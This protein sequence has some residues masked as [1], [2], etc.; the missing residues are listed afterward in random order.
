MAKTKQQ[1]QDMLASYKDRLGQATGVIV[2]SQTG[3]TPGDVSEFKKKLSAVDGSYSVVK[4]TIFK[5]A[6]AE[7]DLPSLDTFEAGPN[8]VIFTSED[9]A[10]TAKIVAEF[11]KQFKNNVEVRG[12][13]L[14]GQ[15]LTMAQVQ[16]LSELP[17][18]EQSIAMIAGLLEQ[19]I[20]GIAYILQNNV[21][22]I[23]IILDKAF[24]E[25]K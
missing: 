18:K 5:I 24:G 12:G 16:E 11:T 14:E 22:S 15:S 6:L 9:V 3:L 1:K 7:S 2:L 10:G 13:I 21:Q 19:N 8:A 20:S 23:A 25:K 4:N 17:T